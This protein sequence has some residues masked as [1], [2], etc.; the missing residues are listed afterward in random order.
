MELYSIKVRDRRQSG[1]LLG[2]KLKAYHHS[3]AVVLG[4]SKGGAL[5]AHAIADYLNLPLEIFPCRKINSPGDARRTIGSVSLDEIVIHAHPY[6]I[7]QDYI[8]RHILLLQ[9][10]LRREVD[11][12]DE[13]WDSISLAG[14]TVIIVD[15]IMRSGDTMATCIRSIEKRHP[16]KIIVAVPFVSAEAVLL[17]EE[18]VE[19]IVYTRMETEID[20]PEDF[21]ENYPEIGEADVKALLTSA[22][23]LQIA[24]H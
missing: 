5:V 2:A 17:I 19:D 22:R 4:V 3:N 12:Y 21:F 13:K 20:S 14:R 15:D 1:I 10:D 7:P 11:F 18:R 23:K 24:L 8:G 16:G 9:N 6:D